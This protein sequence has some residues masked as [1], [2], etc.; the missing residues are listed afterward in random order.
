MLKHDIIVSLVD[1]LLISSA[2]SIS[3]LVCNK[4]SEIKSPMDTVVKRDK[5]KPRDPERRRNIIQAVSDFF[6]KKESPSP[7][8]KSSVFRLTTRS[9]DTGKVRKMISSI[10]ILLRY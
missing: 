10:N 8:H 5:K 9:K 1:L 7:S 4:D 6:K 3:E 2:K